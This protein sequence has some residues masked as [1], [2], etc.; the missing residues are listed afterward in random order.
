MSLFFFTTLQVPPMH[1]HI[2]YS[3][4]LSRYQRNPQSLQWWHAQ[5]TILPHRYRLHQTLPTH[6]TF[7]D[8]FAP[9][10]H[11]P[12]SRRTKKGMEAKGVNQAHSW[13]PRCKRV[14]GPLWGQN[15]IFSK[16]NVSFYP[17]NYD[18]IHIR[19]GPPKRPKPAPKHPLRILL[20]LQDLCPCRSRTKTIN[21]FCDIPVEIQTN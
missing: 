7:A 20:Q 6:S 21:K 11:S 17:R 16:Q 13:G 14:Q 12:A 10:L 15:E 5:S 19:Q 4:A 3:K 2:I 1:I 9:N 8:P 18:K